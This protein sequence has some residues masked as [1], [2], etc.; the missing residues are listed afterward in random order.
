[1]AGKATSV[2]LLVVPI[3]ELKAIFRKVFFTAKEFNEYVKTAEFVE[4]YP[5]D[6]F[7]I[8]KEVY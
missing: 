3:G 5:V 1:M 8:I 2:Y 7:Q 6:K 4:K